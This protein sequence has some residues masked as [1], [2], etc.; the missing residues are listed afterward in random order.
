MVTLSADKLITYV[1]MGHRVS[2]RINPEDLSRTNVEGL[3]QLLRLASIIPDANV[4]PGY[5]EVDLK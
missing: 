4:E 2:A 3:K 1:L 5:L